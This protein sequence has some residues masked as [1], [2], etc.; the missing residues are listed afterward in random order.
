MKSAL[1]TGDVARYCHVTPSTVSRWIKKGYL[2]AY[3][4]PG[5]HYRILLGE[6]RAFLERNSM[7]INEAFFSEVH[8]GAM[9]PD[10]Q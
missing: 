2:R 9:Q 8:E 1:T 4:T 6:F 5:G 10:R 3:A 7:P